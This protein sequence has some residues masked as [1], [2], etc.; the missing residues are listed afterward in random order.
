MWVHISVGYYSPANIK[1][2]LTGPG[3]SP[4]S[5]STTQAFLYAPLVYVDSKPQDPSKE[6]QARG[7][8]LIAITAPKS[9]PVATRQ[10]DL[11]IP[12]TEV[13]YGG[14]S[15]LLGFK[16]TH[17]NPYPGAGDRDVYLLGIS[18]NGLQ[19]ARVGTNDLKDY[20]QYTF[21]DP[22]T[23]M[24][25]TTSPDPNLTDPKKIYLPGTFSSGN[26]FYSPYFS[27][28]VMIYFNRMVDSTFYMR[29][30]NLDNPLGTDTPWVAGGKNGKG[31]LP[32]DAE[33]LVKYAW[34]TEQ[35][36]WAS[37]T[38]KGGFNYAGMAHPEFFN[39]RYFAP[40][41]YPDS[42]SQ[43]HRINDWF[44][45][46]IISEQDGGNDGKNIL[47]SWTGQLR[48][49]LNNGIY[50]VQLAMLSFDDIPQNP[51][52]TSSSSSSG[53]TPTSASSASSTRARHRPEGQGSSLSSFLDYGTH[54]MGKSP[55]SRASGFL[56]LVICGMGV[57]G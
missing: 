49:G 3:T 29:Y 16:S 33:A 18:N 14:F 5:I 30:L 22:E 52:A 25:T 38:S 37:P 13:A 26:I 20:S 57:L 24:F 21:Y 47:L 15:T 9:G 36:L 41:L 46:N 44:G 54:G 42:T 48:G 40:S 55:A 6:Y 43:K 1:C 4:T 32:E 17:V 35:R 23:R 10:G 27:T 19:V 51:A 12:G 2:S 39:R 56:L 45:S 31:I 50:Q 11:I 34:S 8:T 7:M 28:F 53:T